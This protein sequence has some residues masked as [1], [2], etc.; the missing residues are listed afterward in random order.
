M[1]S[2]LKK[3]K[4]EV[5]NNEM[6]YAPVKGKA[7]ASKE[8]SD[9]T[10]G[11]E[12]LGAGMAI[13][14]AEGKVYAPVDG[15]ISMC[16]DSNHAVGIMSDKGTELL[17]HIGLDTVSLKGQHFTSHMKEGDEVKKGDLLIEFDMDAIKT[18]G[19]DMITPVIVTNSFDFKEVI[20]FVDK[21]VEAGDAVMELV[22]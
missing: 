6:I 19:F 14:P 7:V 15:K 21:D 16:I 11:E 2:F 4:E 10:F 17:I 22:K 1:F 9:P 8:V 18:A 5:S 3:K 12:I 20:R 13:I